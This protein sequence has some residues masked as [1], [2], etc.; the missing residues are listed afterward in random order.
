MTLAHFNYATGIFFIAPLRD[1]VRRCQLFLFLVFL[2]S[3]LTVG[4]ASVP[5]RLGFQII[6]FLLGLTDVSAQ[7]LSP[8]AADLAPPEKQGFAYFIVL[9]SMISGV[10]LARVIAGAVAEFRSWRFVYYMAIGAQFLIL[11]LSY[12]IIPDYPAKNSKYHSQTDSPFYGQI[13]IDRA[14]DGANG[15][16]VN[17]HKRLFLKLLGDLVIFTRWT[18]VS[19]LYVDNMHFQ[20]LSR[21]KFATWYGILIGTFLL[22][23]FQGI[24]T[25]AG[26]FSVTGVIISC[27]HASD[28]TPSDKSKLSL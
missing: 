28:L 23:I 4:L 24:Q 15:G 19:L 3:I 6:N 25:A 14:S 27:I 10:L 9:T 12:L 8:L 5:T 16:Y 26:G 2:T 1:F 21:C 13:R 7:I 22:L 17:R 20:L 18:A 11:L